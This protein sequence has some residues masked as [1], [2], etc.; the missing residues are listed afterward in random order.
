MMRRLIYRRIIDATTISASEP[1]AVRLSV[2]EVSVVAE[3][4]QVR[5]R[6][7]SL[8]NVPS[9]WSTE[10][11]SSKP[12]CAGP[13]TCR[14][15]V[16]E[17]SWRSWRGGSGAMPFCAVGVSSIAACWHVTVGALTGWRPSSTILV[18][19]SV[20]DRRRP[21]WSSDGASEQ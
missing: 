18:W 5:L 8:G 15:A 7:R 20:A 2:D 1:S 19:R 6:S 17:L 21:C 4:V 9:M 3:R 10:P 16:V 11:A 12:I 14:L 13:L